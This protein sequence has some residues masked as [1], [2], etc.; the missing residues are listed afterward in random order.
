MHQYQVRTRWTGNLGIGTAGY[1]AYERTHEIEAAGKPPL[2]CSSD[3]SYRGDPTRYNP[4]ELLV[5]SLSACHM[6]W[7]LH[8]CA[9]AGVVVTSYQDD[10]LGS[11][12][13]TPE[14]GGRFTE[15][16]LRPR[17]ALAAGDVATA[18]ALHA[19]AHRLCFIANSV[20][21]PVRHEAKVEPAE[22]VR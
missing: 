1:G 8:L 17:V 21:F 18:R 15:V 7:Y 16:L 9:D 4:E 5:A 19:E 20:N 6:L 2:P 11:M 12:A 22:T 13:T 10:A 14:G 3:P